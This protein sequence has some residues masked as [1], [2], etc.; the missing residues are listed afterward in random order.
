MQAT[1]HIRRRVTRLAAACVVAALIVPAPLAARE[2]GST[3]EARSTQREE[4]SE[5][6]S[7][8]REELAEATKAFERVMREQPIPKATLERAMAI[9]VL[10]GLVQAAFIVGGRGGDGVIARKLA[11]G[12]WSAPAFV[13]VGG[14]TVG[15]QIGG[16]KTDVVLLFMTKKSLDSLLDNRLEFGAEVVAVAGTAQTKP[17]TDSARDDV[18]VYS[19]NTGLFAGAALNG[20]VITPDNDLNRKVYGASAEGILSGKSAIRPPEGFETFN[21]AIRRAMTGASATP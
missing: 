12:G 19:Q 15:A 18:I 4:G 21:Q 5:A 3:R 17:S 6:R 7:E 11:T 10:Q 9:G 1:S 8:A 14:A 2:D 13:K 20:A 16:T